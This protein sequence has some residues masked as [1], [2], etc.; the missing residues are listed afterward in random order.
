M[1]EA[2]VQGK[3][4]SIYEYYVAVALD[5][6]NLVFDFQVSIAG[7][8]VLKG[9]QVIDFIVYSALPTPLEVNEEY[10]HRNK[11]LEDLQMVQINAYLEPKGYAPLIILWGED[12]E[13]QQKADESVREVFYG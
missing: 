1:A 7:G 2:I 10:W 8:R 13:T 3:S 6:L 4:A 12:V 9:G 11:Q 5:K